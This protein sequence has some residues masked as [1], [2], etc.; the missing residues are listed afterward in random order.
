MRLLLPA[1]LL[2][3]C[4]KD[5]APTAPPT[6]P[7]ARPVPAAKAAPTVYLLRAADAPTKPEPLAQIMKEVYDLRLLLAL[8]E[9]PDGKVDLF[10]APAKKDGTQD[11]CAPTTD[12]TGLQPSPDGAIS[13]SGVTLALNADGDPAR[14]MNA[15]VSGNVSGG[16]RLDTV[17]GLLQTADLAPMA[18]K[19]SPP[20]TVCGF[21]PVL[22]PCI[23]CPDG[24]DTCWQVELNT[25]P[26][27]PSTALVE[28]RDQAAIC[29]D[30]AC[31]SAKICR[32]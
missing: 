27:Q 18:G 10:V 29:A 22:G 25:L 6:E 13:V 15:A 3:A 14:L 9:R 4:P 21:L 28:V 24:T 8:R 17:S 20:N 32:P 5:E 31:A 16:L 19:G 2:T 1:L 26:L 12:W 7:S 23:A 11:L 30:P